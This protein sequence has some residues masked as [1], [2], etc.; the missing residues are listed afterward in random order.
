MS[1]NAQ[2]RGTL[3]YQQHWKIHPVGDPPGGIFVEDA[4]ALAR[5][6]LCALDV[7]PEKFV[8]W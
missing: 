2:L 1:T 8:L 4:R 5:A 3:Q 6:G 7:T